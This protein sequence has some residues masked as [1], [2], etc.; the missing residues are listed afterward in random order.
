LKNAQ[1]VKYKNKLQ[2]VIDECNIEGGMHIQLRT[3]EPNA[4]NSLMAI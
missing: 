4:F 1:E 2:K 3:D